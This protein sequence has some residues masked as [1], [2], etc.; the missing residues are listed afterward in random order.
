MNL[1][2]LFRI[3]RDPSSEGGGGA[4]APVVTPEAPAQQQIVTS[5]SYGGSSTHRDWQDPYDDPAFKSQ[6]NPQPPAGQLAPGNKTPAPAAGEGGI[7][8]QP[9]QAGSL[10]PNAS[11]T[12]SG[13]PGQA[14]AEA[15]K[16][17]L[18]D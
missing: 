6:A 10:D 5:T 13:E 7:A 14:P 18:S 17:A 3:L 2:N 8:G 16:G 4:A 11:S 9:A 12:A 1:R 15:T